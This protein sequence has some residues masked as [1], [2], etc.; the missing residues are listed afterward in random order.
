MGLFFLLHGMGSNQV[1][2]RRTWS[3]LRRETL[4]TTYLQSD[5]RYLLLEALETELT[6]LL[7]MNPGS[8]E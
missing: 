2:H 3:C 7:S 1:Q 6:Q 5:T 8:E 4:P